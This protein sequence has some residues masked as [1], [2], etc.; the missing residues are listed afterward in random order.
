M[1]LVYLPTYLFLV[2]ACDILRL[3]GTWISGLNTY[4]PMIWGEGTLVYLFSD[5]ICT[6]LR[7]VFRASLN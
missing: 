3:P 6:L 2:P 5:I 4:L 7:G 1:D